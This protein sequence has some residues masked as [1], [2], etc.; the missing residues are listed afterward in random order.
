MEKKELLYLGKFGFVYDIFDIEN[1][2]QK[3]K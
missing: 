2:C 1:L 3:V